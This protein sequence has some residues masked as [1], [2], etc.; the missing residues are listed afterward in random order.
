MA[1]GRGVVDS[2]PTKIPHLDSEATGV[3][4]TFTRLAGNLPDVAG[5]GVISPTSMDVGRRQ[6]AVSLTSQN[7]GH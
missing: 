4:L 7:S 1:V 5:K 6:D 2:R 3:L